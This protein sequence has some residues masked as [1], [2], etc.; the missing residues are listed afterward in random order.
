MV[1]AWA[2]ASRAAQEAAQS[3]AVC[4]GVLQAAASAAANGAQN[5]LD[6]VATKRRASYLGERSAGHLDPGAVSSS[7]LLD[8]ALKAADKSIDNRIRISFSFKGG[9]RSRR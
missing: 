4:V 8:A 6:M 1:D 7:Y 9:G 2:P 3:G 5:T